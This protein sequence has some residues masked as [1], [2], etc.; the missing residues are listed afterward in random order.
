MG[1]LCV[2]HKFYLIIWNKKGSISVPV[3]IILLAVSV[4]NLVLLDYTRTLIYKRDIKERVRLATMSVMSYYDCVL[5]ERYGL[6]GLCITGSH[7]YNETF[8]E[9]FSGCTFKNDE[10][11][12]LLAYRYVNSVMDA[13]EPF[14][15]PEILS[16]QIV[17]IMKYKSTSNLLNYVMELFKKSEEAESGQKI[18]VLSGEAAQ[19]IENTSECLVLL[20]YS[21][22]GYFPGDRNCVNGFKY[23]DFN[24]LLD[25]ELPGNKGSSDYGALLIRDTL[26]QYLEYNNIA[27][28]QC[29]K[30]KETCYEIETKI[31]QI[32]DMCNENKDAAETFK[33]TL[34]ELTETKNRI[35]NIGVSNYLTKNI[36]VIGDMIEQFANG[37][38]AGNSINRFLEILQQK[39]NVNTDLVVNVIPLEADTDQA[40]LDTREDAQEQYN[41]AVN[42]QKEDKIENDDSDNNSGIIPDTIYKTLPSVLAG[43]DVFNLENILSDAVDLTGFDS[44]A[45]IISGDIFG[46]LKDAGKNLLHTA[47][48]DDYS[49]TYMHNRL[50]PALSS[51]LRSEVEYIIAGNK[52]DKENNKEV[53]N[54]IFLLRF[55][56]NVIHVFRDDAKKALADSIGNAIAAACSY[57]AGGAVFSLLIIAGW[58]LAESIYDINALLDGESIP[59][60]KDKEDWKLSIEG[61][62]SEINPD[63]KDNEESV[64]DKMNNFNYSEYLRVLLMMTPTDTKVLRIADVIELNMGMITGRRYR[65]SGVYNKINVRVFI[66]MNLFSAEFIGKTKEDFYEEVIYAGSYS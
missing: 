10:S 9:Y 12:N 62:I 61:L 35:K 54:K 47:L 14:S 15:D 46:G 17:D 41:K 2:L 1:R 33:S 36:A 59:L 53:R 38:E 48:I 20:E 16:S 21:V 40:K 37:I 44:I 7:D 29:N 49:L 45:T 18:F 25:S 65:L 31:Q 56:L 4:L 26:K 11:I 63:D 64:L 42:L 27:M 32:E 51:V 24:S 58:S 66:D 13:Q 43:K 19:L 57:G 30:L 55:I 8:A 23:I 52:T 3:I 50:S 60:I 22:E 39:E 34:T 5:A 28:Y 6:Y